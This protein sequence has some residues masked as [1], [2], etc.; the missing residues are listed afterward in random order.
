MNSERKQSVRGFTLL[1]LVIVMAIFSI[2]MFGA[3]QLI[4]PVRELY[5]RTN[6]Y[7]STATAVDNMRTYLEGNV[8]PV[9][10]LHVYN[11]TLYGNESGTAQ[12]ITEKE[13]VEKFIRHYH[14]NRVVHNGTTLTTPDSCR[15]ADVDVHVIKIDNTSGGIISKTTYTVNSE[16]TWDSSL[17]AYQPTITAAGIDSASYALNRTYFDNYTYEIILGQNGVLATYDN[18]TYTITAR[19]KTV[20]QHGMQMSESA[21]TIA[22]IG[23]SNVVATYGKKDAS[24]TVRLDTNGDI[25]Y[26]ADG[27]TPMMRSNV[28][29]VGWYTAKNPDSGAVE[30]VELK[31]TPFIMYNAMGSPEVGGAADSNSD[32]IPDE[33]YMV[34]SYPIM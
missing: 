17:S 23:L 30:K 9:E 21:E 25:M 34:F 29:A 22:S 13:A 15:Y 18:F 4:E 24:T 27:V 19:P 12:V 11:G 8:G 33:I 14:I 1:E 2:I 20:T 5:L 16:G 32:S 3:L 28:L 26:E 10:F 6:N 31:E 7:E